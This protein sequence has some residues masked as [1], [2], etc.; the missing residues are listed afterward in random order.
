MLQSFTH[1]VIRNPRKIYALIGLITVAALGSMLRLHLIIDPAA[2]LPASHPFAR[3]HPVL[4]KEFDEH[5]VLLVSMTPTDGNISAKPFIDKVARLTLALQGTP[6]VAKATLLS[7]THEHAKAILATGDGFEVRALRGVLG[8]PTRLQGWLDANPMLRG[9]VIAN[10]GKSVLVLARFLPDPAGY[11]AVLNRTEPLIDAERDASVTIGT[12]GSVKI[13]GEIERSSKRMLVLIPLAILLIALIQFEAFRSWQGMVLP[14]VTAVLA[15]IWVLGIFGATGTPLDVFNSTTPMLI[16]AVAAGHATQILKRYYEE[17]DRLRASTELTPVEANREAV[18]AAIN[19][20]GRQMIVAGV[21]AALGFLSLTVFEIKSVRIFGLFTGLGILSA[22]I[23]E[24][25]FIPALRSRLKPPAYPRSSGS[26]RSVWDAAL[27]WIGRFVVSRALLPVWAALL[28]I[29]AFGAA[30]VTIDNSNK[31]NFAEWTQ[32]RKDDSF[33][34]ERFAGTQILYIVFDTGRPDGIVQPAVLKAMDV[35]QS[36]LTGQPGVGKTVSIIDYV[37]RMN[38]AMNGDQPGSFTVPDDAALVAQ[39][40]LLYGSSGDAEDLTSFVDFDQR[41]AV[42]KVFVKRDDTHF[43]EGLIA[44]AQQLAQ[45]LP[46]GVVASYGGSVAEAAAVNETLAR[47]KLLNIAQIM[48]AVF[49]LSWLFFRSLIAA[50]LVTLPLAI[51]VLGNFAILGWLDIPLNIPTSLISAMAVGIGADYA[52][53]VLS[54]FREE[55]RQ[56]PLGPTYDSDV[57]Q[58]TLRSAGNACL[59]VAS[60]VTIGYGVL[61]F[62][63]GFKAHQWLALLIGC[64]M[65]ISAIATLTLLCGIVMRMKP[66]F[67]WGKR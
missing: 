33:I 14:L 46:P 38:Q 56:R 36:D 31:A 67:V 12:G 22:L 61:A 59:Y 62:S 11:S 41:K 63:F 24:L 40:L 29:A 42:L 2:I 52:I 44:R 28:V 13:M 58:A 1:W 54:R 15:P 10:D 47:D 5:Y 7:P 65:L 20:V 16:L 19:K 50:C 51:A 3:T 57:L 45:Q 39:Y 18:V 4:E 35:I 60:A 26:R 8:E 37:K 43:T 34:N 27:R 9:T 53:Y 17:Y 32:L 23:I 48:A 64:A 6:G 55:A 30:Q 66:S 21:I 49:V 25:T